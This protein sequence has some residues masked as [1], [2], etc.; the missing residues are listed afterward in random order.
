LITSSPK[1]RRWKRSC[2]ARSLSCA[3]VSDRGNGACVFPQ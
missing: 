3:I 1:E 2:A